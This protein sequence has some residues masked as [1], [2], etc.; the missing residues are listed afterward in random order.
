MSGW[1]GLAGAGRRWGV[2]LSERKGWVGGWVGGWTYLCLWLDA[3]LSRGDEMEIHP[4]FLEL[5]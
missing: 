1:V 3:E 5:L 4:S 2:W